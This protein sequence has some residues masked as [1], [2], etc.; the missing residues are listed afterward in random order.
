MAPKPQLANFLAKSI[1]NGSLTEIG[2]RKRAAIVLGRKWPFLP[3]F[4]KRVIKAFGAGRRPRQ[5]AL[6][7]FIEKDAGFLRA[8]AKNPLAVIHEP[9]SRPRMCPAAGPPRT[10]KIL[11]ICT[12]SALAR[13]LNLKPN[14]LAWFADCRT[15]AR[16]LPDGPLRHYRYR[17]Q[18]KRDGTFRLI[19][20]PKQ[21]LKAMLRFLLANVVDAIPSHQA[22]HGFR[23][24]RSIKSFAETHVAK[25]IVLKLDLKDFFPSISRA[26]ILSIFLTAGYPENV[27]QILTGLCVTCVPSQ[28]IRD[29]SE[30][31]SARELRALKVL[32]QRPHLPQGAPTSP[33]LANLAAYRLDCRLWGLAQGAGAD[34]TRY[35]DDLV[36]SGGT[37]FARGIER[38]YIRACAIAL[39][40]GFEVNTRKTKVMRKSVSQRVAGIVLNNQINVPRENYDQVKAMVHN[41]V[42]HGPSQQNRANLPDF[43]AHLRGRIAHIE[44]LNPK[45]GQKLRAQFQ[46]IDW[47]S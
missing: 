12:V 34:Y 7:A 9:S 41:C 42:L 10:W 33:A 36:F 45:R 14:E 23:S 3:A 2:I 17:W 8:Q 39:E 1:L 38:F 16:R 24:G 22:V 27:A 15:Q 40:E 25:A 5:V 4:A 28:I 18:P 30:R 6:C 43:R 31:I 47:A 13:R 26:R 20:S 44:I 29:L 35:A 21:R 37:E 46:E 19:E 32:Y 11:P